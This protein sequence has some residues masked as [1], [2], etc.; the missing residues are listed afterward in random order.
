MDEYTCPNCGTRS[1]Y[2]QLISEIA[3]YEEWQ[4]THDYKP[5]NI[6]V[7]T[8]E[9]ISV[10]TLKCPHCGTVLDEI[11]STTPVGDGTDNIIY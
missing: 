8:Y 6:R 10:E 1:K 11:L 2:K 5:K 7:A 4:K 3:L 9:E